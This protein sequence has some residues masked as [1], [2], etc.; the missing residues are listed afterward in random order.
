MSPLQ[1][2]LIAACSL[3]IACALLSIFVVLRHWAFIGEGIAHAA[4]GGAGTA[5]MLAL[6]LPSSALL[7]SS[8][9]V[10]AVAIL[11]CLIVGLAIALLTRRGLLHADTAI[12]IFL[13]ASLAWGFI[14]SGVYRMVHRGLSPPDIDQ[15]LIGH[16]ELLPATY[17]VIAALICLT[18]VLVVGA[19]WKEIVCYSFDP[20][21]AE[22]S[23]VPVGLIHYLLALLLTVTI[24]VGIRIMG[25]LLM[26]ALLVLPG[27]TALL[28]SRRLAG[29]VAAA[30]GVGLLGA[31]A[32]PLI[33]QR[34]PF[35]PAGPAIVMCLVGQFVLAFLVQHLPGRRA[36]A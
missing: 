27:A 23:G 22:V 3:G 2:E 14:A 13:V 32:G 30:V 34:W 29:V 16:M 35:I 20:A 12:G 36:G 8:G 26:T 17:V 21:L 24:I 25:S 7:A 11:F 28:L 1:G 4:F 31:V 9:G 33:N 19:L 6:L 10:Y 5:W 18:V 15:Y